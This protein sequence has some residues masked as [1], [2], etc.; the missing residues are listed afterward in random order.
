L[1]SATHFNFASPQPVPVLFY[2]PLSKAG[3]LVKVMALRKRFLSKPGYLRFF[4]HFIKEYI[5]TITNHLQRIGD[6]AAQALVYVDGRDY[7]QAHSA[8]DDI[9][10]GV[11]SARVHLDHLQDVLPRPVAPA[12]EIQ[13]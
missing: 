3:S 5:V 2:L 9:E 10:S 13:E 11:H 6:L 1:F 12:V 7:P 4:H 8:L